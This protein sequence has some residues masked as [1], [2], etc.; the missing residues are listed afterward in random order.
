[1]LRPVISYALTSLILLSQ[2]GLP[3]HRHYCK[4]ILESVSILFSSS[5]D[6]HEPPAKKADCCKKKTE[7][8]CKKK[9]TKKCCDDQVTVIKQ[10]ITSVSPSV[11]KWIDV[12]VSVESTLV[13]F[14]QQD[15]I[16]IA[17]PISRQSTDSGPPIYVLH[18]ALIFYA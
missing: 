17:Q 2:A 11:I 13:P 14:I 8:H 7:N 3:L 4:G 6:N 9:S 16:S 1:M 5:C 12:P 18:Q 10:N 15:D